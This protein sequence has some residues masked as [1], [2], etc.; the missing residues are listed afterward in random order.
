M[1]IYFD[2]QGLAADNVLSGCILWCSRANSA[3][4]Y[5]MPDRRIIDAQ[6]P[7]GALRE[8]A[9][10]SA[11]RIVDDPDRDRVD[12]TL[13]EELHRA[14][15]SADREECIAYLINALN[16]GLSRED[17][18]DYYI[19]A[20]A[21]RMGDQWCADEL[22]FAQ[23]TIGVSRLQAMLRQLG[24]EW[25]SD[26]SA[27]PCAASILLVVPRD[28]HHTLGAVVLAGQLRRRGLSVRLMLN[29][30]PK[31]VADRVHRTR[32][33]AVFVSA[34]R[35]EALESLRLIADAVKT[36]MDRPPPVVIGGTVLDVHAV[37]DVMRLTGADYA[38]G[39]LDEA[40]EFCDLTTKPR[41]SATALN[42]T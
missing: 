23:V 21:R 35:G 3:K 29:A 22:G 28:V 24:P 15:L 12:P 18:A 41:N 19:P 2:I 1:S 17:M 32:Y 25:A 39:H 33:D 4:G 5:E 38:T 16:G 36:V 13:F 9:V 10:Q 30:H 7:Q 11:T 37:N 40:I 14:A 20:L 31:E 8:K 6:A 42:R 34:S 27:D 26:R